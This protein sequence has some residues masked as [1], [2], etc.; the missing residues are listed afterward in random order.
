MTG[1]GY[2]RGSPSPS[3]SV[4]VGKGAGLVREPQQR[5]QLE[6]VNTLGIEIPTISNAFHSPIPTIRE[7][8][9]QISKNV[10]KTPKNNVK[11]VK[12]VK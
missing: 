3:K 7:M 1:S 11:Y 9:I 6:S 8:K 4:K 2:G 5:P 12:Y 10:K